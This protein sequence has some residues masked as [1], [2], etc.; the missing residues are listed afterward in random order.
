MVLGYAVTLL[1]GY[2]LLSVPNPAWPV[3]I[4]YA[5]WLLYGLLAL[6]LLAALIR[7]VKWVWNWDRHHQRG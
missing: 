1:L 3:L 6:A 5:E 2:G 4:V 7:F